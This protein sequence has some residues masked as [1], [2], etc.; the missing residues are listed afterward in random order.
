MGVDSSTISANQLV[1]GYV[2]ASSIH[3]EII[4]ADQKRPVV[5]CYPNKDLLDRLRM[6]C[7]ESTSAST[8]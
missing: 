1:S 2:S 5:A 8:V 3:L 4:V 6:E 7:M